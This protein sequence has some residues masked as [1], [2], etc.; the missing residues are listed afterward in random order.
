MDFAISYFSCSFPVRIVTSAPG[1]P[2]QRWHLKPSKEVYNTTK[3]API[4]ESWSE[5]VTAFGTW[6]NQL[7]LVLL[8]L[9]SLWDNQKPTTLF[10]VHFMNVQKTILPEKTP[11]LIHAN[12][13]SVDRPGVLANRL[14]LLKLPALGQELAGDGGLH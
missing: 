10:A 1:C 12:E 13:L 6:R 5:L 2:G 11:V 4:F 3:T 7:V 9:E 14:L 8:F